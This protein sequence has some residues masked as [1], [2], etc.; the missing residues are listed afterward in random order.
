[1][2]DERNICKVRV[3]D[4]NRKVFKYTISMAWDPFCKE[5]TCSIFL[6]FVVQ[7]KKYIP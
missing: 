6:Q 7:Y 2:M 5:S 4:I 3:T 1:M